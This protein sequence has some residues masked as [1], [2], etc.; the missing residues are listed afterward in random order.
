MNKELKVP[1]HKVIGAD[2]AF[3]FPCRARGLDIA[4]VAPGKGVYVHSR[5]SGNCVD[6]VVPKSLL[7]KERQA[8]T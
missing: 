2:Q 1:A 3:V 8:E 7:V 5:E 6:F 4:D